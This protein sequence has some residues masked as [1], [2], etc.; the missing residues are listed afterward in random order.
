MTRSTFPF[1]LVPLAVLLALPAPAAG[2]GRPAPARDEEGFTATPGA[3]LAAARSES[4]PDRSWLLRPET[5]GRLSSGGQR[6]ARALN[7]LAPLPAAVRPPSVRP[8]PAPSTAAAGPP[9]A[10]GR[11]SG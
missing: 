8:A 10:A 2:P 3:S 7:G 11:T 4:A 5:F 9:P 6:L 1:G